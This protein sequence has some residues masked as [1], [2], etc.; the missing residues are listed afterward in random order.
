MTRA[1]QAREFEK[2]LESMEWLARRL[3]LGGAATMLANTAGDLRREYLMKLKAAAWDELQ[4]KG[5]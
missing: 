4:R 2:I 5:K 1:E 3:S